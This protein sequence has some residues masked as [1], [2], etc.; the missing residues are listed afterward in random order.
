[1]AGDLAQVS[2]RLGQKLRGGD[3]P[4]LY[5]ETRVGYFRAGCR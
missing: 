2:E 1:M 5:L 4:P 3:T